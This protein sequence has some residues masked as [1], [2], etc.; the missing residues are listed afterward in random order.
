MSTGVEEP[1]RPPQARPGRTPGMV[2]ARLIGAL[3]LG[4]LTLL[5]LE[6]FFVPLLWAAIL[7]FIT[8]PLYQ[9]LADRT[10]HREL[11]AG[12]FA[13]AVALS[14]GIP[15]ALVLAN[16]ASE[17]TDIARRVIAW[18]QAGAPLPIWITESELG[19]R[20][21]ALLRDS[22]LLDPERIGETLARL[23]N[24]AAGT[25]VSLA[26]GVA[27]NM[28]KFGVMMVGLY[29]FYVSGEHI[30]ELGRRL[31]PLLFPAAPARFVESIGDS[32]RAV[33]YGLAGTAVA[34]GIFA[35]V[36]MA[37]L[38]VPSPVALG[39]ATSLT[40]VFPGG[41]SAITLAAAVWLFFEGRYW[42][43][44]GLAAWGVLVVA[45]LDNF[46]RPL[47]ISGRAPIPFLVV[48]LGILGGLSAF[49][50]VGIFLGPVLL[51]VAFTLLTEFARAGDR[52]PVSEAEAPADE[53]RR[54]A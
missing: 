40:A 45:S 36:G 39:T 54:T 24:A 19:H 32:V 46:L 44:L 38:G 29:G 18:Q 13:L 22:H 12:L 33:M 10:R 3:A 34:Q 15:L 41:G 5:V 21:V 6:P 35:G 43:A 8:W 17:L 14:F 20:A 7:A 37:V 30:V 42:A 31:A 25:V 27:R 9:R 11:A 28:L 4:T 2:A 1:P 16:L 49:G 51:S 47:L 50:V 53:A 23:G 52:E 48:F 26:G